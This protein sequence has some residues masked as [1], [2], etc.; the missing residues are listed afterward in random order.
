MTYPID[1]NSAKK[2]ND[3]VGCCGCDSVK[4]VS[5]NSKNDGNRGFC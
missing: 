2:E 3:F 4:P 1:I 5:Y